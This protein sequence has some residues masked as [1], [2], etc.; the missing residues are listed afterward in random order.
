MKPYATRIDT[1]IGRIE[2]PLDPCFATDLHR[3]K[4]NVDL[5]LLVERGGYIYPD[6]LN[7]I[8]VRGLYNNY[9]QWKESIALSSVSS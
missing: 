9:L 7:E 4:T 6:A 1:P 3:C 5:F 2:A 8:M